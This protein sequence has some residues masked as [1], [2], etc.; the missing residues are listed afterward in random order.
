MASAPVTTIATMPIWLQ[1]SFA[2]F[3]IEGG[4]VYERKRCAI[5]ITASPTSPAI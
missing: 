1:K 3:L 2:P 5:D 4:V